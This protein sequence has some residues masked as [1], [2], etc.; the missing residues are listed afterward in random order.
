MTRFEK[1][2]QS[3]RRLEAEVKSLKHDWLMAD[4]VCDKKT[5]ENRELSKLAWEVVKYQHEWDDNLSEAITKLDDY[6][7]DQIVTKIRTDRA[8]AEKANLSDKYKL[9]CIKNKPFRETINPN[10]NPTKRRN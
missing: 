2:V 9:D 1:E 5:A 4:E 3:L 8:T 6:L 7:K 10:Y